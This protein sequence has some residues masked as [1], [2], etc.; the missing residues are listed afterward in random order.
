MRRDKVEPPAGVDLA[1]LALRATY[2]GSPEHKDIPSPAG[3]PRRRSDATLCPRDLSDPAAVTQW[4]REA[5]AAGQV[6]AP[7][8]EGV[9]FPR[10]AWIRTDLGCFEARLTNQVSGQYKGY[11]LE[12]DEAP[13]WL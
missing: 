9:E 8:P 4:L 3:Q 1:E 6:G 13:L 11:L 2:T 5:I 7:W 12:P 10:Y